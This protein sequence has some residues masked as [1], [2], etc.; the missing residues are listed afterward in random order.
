MDISSGEES[1]ISE[2][3]IKNYM[4]KPYEQLRTGIYKVK[5]VNGTLRCPFCAGKKK[6][7]Y[8]YKDLLQHASGVGKGSANRSAKQ[9]AEHLALAKYLEIDLSDEAE[10]AQGPPLPQP[11]SQT[12]KDDLYVWPWT[13]IMVNIQDQ[14]LH[15]SEYWFR[16][17]AKYRPLDVLVLDELGVTAQAVV[18]FSDD[19]N[20][21]LNASE[22]EKS[23]E[24][25]DNGKTDWKLHSIQPGSNIYGWIA[26]EDDYHCEGPIGEYLRMKGSL[27]RVSDIVNESS[28]S[29]HSVVENLANEIDMTNENLTELECKYNETAL[30]L[31]RV[32][33]EKDQ[34]QH[35][36][37]EERKRRN[38]SAWEARQRIMDEQEKLNKELEARKRKLDLW[39]R[40]L[41]EREALTE[42]QRQKLE[43]D[44]RK[45]DL[46]NESLNKA[47]VEWNKTD[48]NVSRIIEEQ[49][50]EKEEALRR[51]FELEKQLDEKQQLE[52]EIELLKGKLNMRKHLGDDEALQKKIKEKQEEL[53]EKELDF[54][55]KNFENQTLIVKDCQSNNE[56]QE[57]RKEFIEA[58]KN[59]LINART[60]I[61]IKRMGEL[62]E[63]V[64]VDACKKNLPLEDAQIKGVELCSSWQ[65]N[66]KNSE[67]Y[68]FKVIPTD[69]DDVELILN[70]DD[71]KLR[72]LKKEWGDNVYMEV[73]TA[74]KEIIE[75]NPSG[76]Y[77]VSEIWNYRENRKAMMKEAV[78]YILEK[79]KQL[80]SKRTA[81]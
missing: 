45:N 75:Y 18:V 81:R 41:N 58:S 64:F 46:R 20:G 15:N 66:V 62:N 9:K 55:V 56:V 72:K 32:L 57:A 11:T 73:V 29:R 47:A 61:G 44:K 27:K 60:N 22:F 80:K 13:G 12:Q 10:Q 7:D 30:S 19:W 34:L 69:H 25:K 28:K 16:E 63:K 67:W 35:A 77:I 65:E 71:E 3:E 53:E 36:L 78:S 68:P 52:M 74:L 38:V 54:E 26:R 42:Q 21:F 33:E 5:N 8:K 59:I 2:S 24:S 76:R 43:E 4:D 1:D 17:L 39:S 79:I 31:C 23:F 37:L 49:K 6:Q 48:A 51:I 40:D 14:S 50:R 70:E